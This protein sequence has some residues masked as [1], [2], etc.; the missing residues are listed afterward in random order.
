[1][2]GVVG[3]GDEAGLHVFFLKPQNIFSCPETQENAT[4]IHSTQDNEGNLLFPFIVPLGGSQVLFMAG[5]G[6]TECVCFL[7]TS[8]SKKY[9]YGERGRVTSLLVLLWYPRSGSFPAGE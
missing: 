9:T 3:L 1:M 5:C 7:L 4:G 6:C 2:S 8:V